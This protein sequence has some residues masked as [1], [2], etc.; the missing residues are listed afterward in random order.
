MPFPYVEP[1]RLEHELQYTQNDFPGIEDGSDWATLLSDS[2]KTASE[3]VDG[4]L[5]SGTDWRDADSVPFVIQL[6]VIRLA[7]ARIAHI[8]EDG[9]ES[10][11][12]VSGANYDYRPPGELREEIRR[13]LADAGYGTN[14]L[15][16]LVPDTPGGQPPY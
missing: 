14:Q 4:W 2:L 5:D 3:R 10:E 11:G 16:F 1:E 9:I 15:D 8:R 13:Q 7:R 12:L 6:A